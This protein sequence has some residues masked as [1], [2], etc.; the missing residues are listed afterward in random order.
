MDR[1]T[2]RIENRSDAAGDMPEDISVLGQGI[3]IGRK[4]D[5][6]WSLPDTTRFISGRHVKISF[7]SGGYVLE[8]VSTNGTFMR[9]HHHPCG[10][11][12]QAGTWRHHP[13]RQLCRGGGS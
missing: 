10:W 2:L 12:A 9:R 7:E 8:D 13:D 3:S 6:D 11:Q 5:N 1:L 4:M